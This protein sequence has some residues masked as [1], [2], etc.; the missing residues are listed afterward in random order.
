VTTQPATEHDLLGIGSRP[1]TLKKTDAFE[2]CCRSCARSAGKKPAL[3][4]SGQF[5]HL[6]F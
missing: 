6:K 3:T 5:F 4:S 2:I 1:F